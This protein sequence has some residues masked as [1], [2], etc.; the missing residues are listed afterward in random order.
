MPEQLDDPPDVFYYGDAVMTT[1]WL[2]R[3]VAMD[4]GTPP[5]DMFYVIATRSVG[6]FKGTFHG[7]MPTPEPG[8]ERA[9]VLNTPNLERQQSLM[10]CRQY[11][12]HHKTVHVS[13]K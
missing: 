13:V 12:H 5:S 1:K 4:V 10:R 3:F 9:E 8:G 7:M 6:R 2:R 11:R